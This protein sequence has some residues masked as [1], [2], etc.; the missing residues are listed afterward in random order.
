VSPIQS[1]LPLPVDDAIDGSARKRKA[2]SAAEVIEVL[3]ARYAA[4]A[5]AFL[6]QVANGTGATQHRWA[7]ALAMSLWPSR[8]IELYGIEV[9]VSR[10]DWLTEMK[11]PAK[12]EAIARYC[13]RWYL[14]VSDASIVLPGE[15][16]QQ[17]GLLALKRGRIQCVQEA[18]A[19]TPEP[20]SLE[21][22]AA[23][24]RNITKL[25]DA[26][27][28]AAR[29]QAVAEAISRHRKSEEDATKYQDDRVQ[30]LQASVAAFEDA[31]GLKINAYNGPKIGEAVRGLPRAQS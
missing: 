19:R 3:R 24:M 20:L 4:P 14:A 12:A 30:A 21:I 10:G 27:L 8:G 6:G 16:P 5:Y 26:Q 29:E 13:N 31:S 17:W 15:L 25:G 18:P 22:L 23:I 28:R 7:D 2:I 11:N 1:A 9:K